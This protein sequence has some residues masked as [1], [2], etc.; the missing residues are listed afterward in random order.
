ME[1]ELKHL[2]YLV[3]HVLGPYVLQLLHALGLQPADY[4]H[5]IPEYVVMSL[6]VLVLG[7]ILALILRSRLSVERPGVFQQTAELL[8]TNP[9]GFGIK[10]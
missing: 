7:T 1:H 9:M 6:V 4:D 10:D 3:N 5:P 2:T 8:L